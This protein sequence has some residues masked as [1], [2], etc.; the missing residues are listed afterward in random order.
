MFA[1]VTTSW[2]S[3]RTNN[4]GLSIVGLLI[5]GILG[6]GLMA[7][8]PNEKKYKG[9]KLAEIYLIEFFGPSKYTH[10]SPVYQEN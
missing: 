2:I 8:L 7:F 9:G 1:V 10:S 3:G 4:R 6:G 5:P